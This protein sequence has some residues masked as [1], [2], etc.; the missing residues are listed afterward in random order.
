MSASDDMLAFT[1]VVDHGSFAKAAAE[2]R[3][4]PSALSK[5]ISRLEDR[6]GVRLLTRT[7][8]SLSLTPEGTLYLA[9]ARDV[10]GLIERAEAEVSSSAASPK[11]RLRINTGTAMAKRIVERVIPDF[12]A[13][14]PEISIELMVAD[15]IV[16]PIAEHV[17]IALR[18]GP[19]AD[20]GLIARKLADFSRMIC[21]APSYL[22]RHGTPKVP[23]DL[24]KHNCLTLAGLVRLNAW[25]FATGDGINR[26]EVPGNFSSDHVGMLLDM[27]LQGH[28]I[29]RLAN[30][31]LARP[32][33][34][35]H[36]VELLADTHMSEPV[37]LWALMP[38]G[39]H[40]AP[41]VQAFADFLADKLAI[42]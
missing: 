14:Y 7:T 9:S 10:L 31:V 8:R 11:G 26:L 1:S 42:E 39:R 28:G 2:L 23:A 24:L 12:L 15:R 35:G 21:A 19:L 3:L 27:A 13:R 16:D 22:A 38:P 6:L 5:A 41:R 32:V 25:P 20:S 37:P 30:F 33:R 36:L 34:E 18:T 4:T 29:V 40:R 17:D